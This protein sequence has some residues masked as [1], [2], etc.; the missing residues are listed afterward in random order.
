MSID[1][2]E[3]DSL[4]HDLGTVPLRVIPKVKSSVSKGALQIKNQMIKDAQS[5][6][7]FKAVARAIDYDLTVGGDGISAEIGPSSSKDS[8]AGL[9]GAYWG[10]SNGGGGT[11]PDPSIALEAEVPKFMEAL[12]K[13][14]GYIF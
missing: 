7:S 11:L 4:A 13:E 14:A 9:S 12:A 10:W 3:L 2:S 5:S 8:A 6:T 1:A